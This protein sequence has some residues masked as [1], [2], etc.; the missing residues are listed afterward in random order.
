MKTITRHIWIGCFATAFII[1]ISFSRPDNSVATGGCTVP[2]GECSG[3]S[4]IIDL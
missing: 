2:I 1:L 4:T 3:T